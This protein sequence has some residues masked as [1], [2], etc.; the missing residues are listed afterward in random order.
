MSTMSVTGM[1][2][3]VKDTVHRAADLTE[4]SQERS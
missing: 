3:Y 4:A 2:L 1:P